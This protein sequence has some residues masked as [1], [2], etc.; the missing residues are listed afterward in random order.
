MASHFQVNPSFVARFEE[1]GMHF[2]GR[3]VDGERME[4]L[5]IE[6]TYVLLVSYRDCWMQ[7]KARYEGI[8]YCIHSTNWWV[9]FFWFGEI[10]SWSLSKGLIAPRCGGGHVIYPLYYTI[11]QVFG[12]H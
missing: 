12:I 6:G 5:E 1:K 10:W 9:F 2:V 3:D 7:L 4:I 8:Q 11:D